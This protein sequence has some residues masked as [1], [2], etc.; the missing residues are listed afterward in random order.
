M[1]VVQYGHHMSSSHSNWTEVPISF[2]DSWGVNSKLILV[3]F[4]LG[5]GIFTF[6]FFDLQSNKI[7]SIIFSTAPI[8]LPF[9]TFLLFFEYWLEYVRK[10]YDIDYGRTTIEIKLPQEI[11]KSPQAMEM[12]ITQLYQKASP[13][14]HKETYID[15]KNRPT[16]SLEIVSRGGDVHFYMNI[17]KKRF[18]DLIE[19][20]LYAYYPGIEVHELDID[21]TAEVPLDFKRFFYFSFHVRTKKA[22]ALPIKTYI[23]YGLDELPKEEEKIDPLNS[24][25]EML[26]NIKPYEQLWIQILIQANRELT[27]KDGSLFTKPDWKEEARSEIQNIIRAAAKRVG[28]NELEVGKNV[29]QFLSDAEKETVRAIERTLGKYAFNTL[30]RILYVT[31]KDKVRVSDVASGVLTALYPFDDLN[32]NSLGIRWRTDFDWNWWQDPTGHRREHM[33]ANELY[34]YKRRIIH[35]QGHYG[36][37]VLTTEELATIYH[38]PGKVAGTPT[39]SRIPSKRSEAPSN[40]PVG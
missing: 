35:P 37:C 40:L 24:I 12:V 2:L 19:A 29:N 20:Q 27:F 21:Y 22:D 3:I 1:T 23:E 4:G 30:I 18:K 34:D 38:F 36:P 32:R 25:L 31:E 17:P 10:A 6:T 33:R 9:T 11:L 28:V 7:F 5:M 16:S 13:D 26:G 39:L 8:W 15:G 14:N